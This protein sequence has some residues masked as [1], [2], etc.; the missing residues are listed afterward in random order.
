MTESLINPNQ[1]RANGIV[2]DDCPKQFSKD[3]TH[4]I[5]DPVTKV[6]IPLDMSDI[7]SGFDTFQANP[8]RVR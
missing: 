4:S 7:M 1:L 2:V 6:T 5:Y 8:G 3:S